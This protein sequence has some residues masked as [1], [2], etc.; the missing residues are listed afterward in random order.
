MMKDLL[1]I[2]DLH[3]ADLELLLD[4]AASAAADPKRPDDVLLGDTVA[5]YFATPAIAASRALQ[6]AVIRLGGMPLLI[7]PDQ[8]HNAAGQTIHDIACGGSCQVHAIVVHG[9]A[10]HDLHQVAAAVTVPVVNAASHCHDPW[11]ALAGLLTLRQRWGR[12][13]GHRLAY[14]GNGGSLAHS[15]L[16]AAALAGMDIAVA[17]PY[18]LEPHPE[19]VARARALVAKRGGRVRLRLDPAAAVRGADAV[20]TD[21][22]LSPY[23]P[24]GARAAREFVLAPYRVDG[25]L[26]AGAR[27]EVLL[28]HGSLVRRGREVTDEVLQ[29]PRSL[30]V[31]QAANLLPVAEAMLRLLLTG[32]LQ[33]QTDALPVP[34]DSG[35]LVAAV[36]ALTQGDGR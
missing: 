21:A 4:Q 33:G 12:L 22:W 9:A 35:P 24:A 27:P 36:T 30:V 20:V 18:G 25:R 15:L 13:A 32:R 23:D 29:G 5:L 19:V 14:V 8:L 16:E 17:T 34:D 11:Q 6:T 31:E 28:L 7:G 3:P 26:L 1:R 2:A 10:D